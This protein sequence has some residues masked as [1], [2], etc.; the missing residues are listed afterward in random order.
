MW[1]NFYKIHFFKHILKETDVS[2]EYKMND[3]LK[4]DFVVMSVSLLSGKNV[5]ITLP[6]DYGHPM[7]A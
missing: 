6:T 1:T 3:Y 7:K 4:T 5:M 2:F